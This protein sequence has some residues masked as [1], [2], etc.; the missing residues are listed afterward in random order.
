[1]FR[2]GFADA[3][4]KGA[5]LLLLTIVVASC[6]RDYFL[7]TRDP[8]KCDALLN[9]GQWLESPDNKPYTKWQPSGCMF[10]QYSAPEIAECS[11]DGDITIVGD[12][13]V[14]QIFWALARKIEDDEGWVEEERNKPDNHGDL[15]YSKGGVHL[16]FIWDPWL[17]STAMFRELTLLE[18][19]VVNETIVNDNVPSNGSYLET[20]PRRPVTMLIGGGL[21]YARHME[22][23]SIEAYSQ[24]IDRI[25]LAHDF[26]DLR[27]LPQSTE[28]V[29]PQVFIAPVIEPLYYMLSPARQSTITPEKISAM[30]EYLG[31]LSRAGLNVVWSYA[32]MM[33]DQPAAY[34][35]SGLHV[36][37][38]VATRMTDVLLNLRC[39]GKA[40][41]HLTY[42]VN[43][44]CCSSYSSP[45]WLYFIP[46]FTLLA[47]LG[48]IVLSKSRHSALS[49]SGK[50][51]LQGVTIAIRDLLVVLFFCV[52]ADRTH[53][54]DK[55]PGVY[56]TLDYRILL[57]TITLA[58]LFTIYREPSSPPDSQERRL[59]EFSG[60]P[61]TEHQFLPR[62]QG[63]EIRGF[64][65]IFI[66]IYGFLGASDVLDLYELFRVCFAMYLFLLGYGHTMYFL[67]KRDFSFDRV[68]IVLVRMNLLAVCLSFVMSRP[69]LS[70][71]WAPLVSFWFFVVYVTMRV[72]HYRNDS[73]AFLVAKIFVSALAVT[74]VVYVKGPLH[75]VWLM[76]K[77]FFRTDFVIDDWR[78]HVGTETYIV[79]V[80]MLAAVIAFQIVGMFETPPAQRSLSVE[81][82]VD[83][84]DTFRRL[85][86]FCALIIGPLFWITA[87]SHTKKKDYDW[88]MPFLSWMPV[89]S[90]VILRNSLQFL[91]TRHCRAF[92][93]VG[94]MSLELHLLSQ[95]IFLAADGHGTLSLGLGGEKLTVLMGRWKELVLLA[96]ILVWCAWKVSKGTKVLTASITGHAGDEKG[97]SQ[98]RSADHDNELPIPSTQGAMRQDGISSKLRSKRTLIVLML[99]IWVAKLCT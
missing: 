10:H 79:F 18:G 64:M 74:V 73:V 41:Q 28:G 76:L 83:C 97:N 80:G 98:A 1:M 66:L 48:S 68:A 59:S 96:P 26:S 9:Q 91:R 72:V 57:G 77:V 93:W 58:C 85:F 88:F 51:S 21:W 38:P 7:D 29:G 6:Y 3:F 24:S 39:N 34:S 19:G 23:T 86:V 31:L 43:K 4:S 75:L 87:Q 25:S 82:L 30:N 61:R 60:G 69:Y 32:K 14:R 94:R 36:M 55:I 37:D 40:T 12:S 95:H 92:A 78:G 50:G 49:D 71:Y 16:K 63:D 45:R 15:E 20:G 5:L 67:Q 89:V 13:T 70:Y 22:N 8:Y 11:Q 53:T 84:F 17:N 52:L 62:I 35:M 54:L 47:R 27:T 2:V 42:P 65:Q 99:A 56:S 90:I 46:T 81:V 44:T 33:K